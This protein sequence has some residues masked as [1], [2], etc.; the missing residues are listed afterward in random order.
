MMRVIGLLAIIVVSAPC[1]ARAAAPPITAAA[2]SPDGKSI[3]IGSQRGIEIRNWPELE[4]VG[5]LATQ[6]PHVHALAFSS[7]GK[8]L[9]AGGGEPADVGT[10]E[11]FAWPDGS[12]ADHRSLFDDLTLAVAWQADNSQLVCASAD[13]S[14]SLVP[15]SGTGEQRLEKP[16]QSFSGH[17]RSVL[18]AVFLPGGQH[19]VSAGVDQSLRVWDSTTGK[20]LRTLDQH[21]AEVVDLEVRPNTALDRPMIASASA[22]RTVRLWQPTIGRLVR[23]VRLPV[24][25]LDIAWTRDGGRLLASCV[26][27]HLRVID[28]EAVKVVADLPAIDGWAYVVAAS[29]IG[30]EVFI[31]GAKGQMK[32]IEID[33]SNR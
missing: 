24:E 30:N 18:S 26:D 13:Q 16:S 9:A 23:F 14:V 28:P 7:N 32:R 29:P 22:D 4:N 11:L 2:F 21:T 12:L 10:V 31:G 1:A 6:L 20:L 5:T 17:S 15:I 19:V 8:W 27:G 25:P 33:D 3:V